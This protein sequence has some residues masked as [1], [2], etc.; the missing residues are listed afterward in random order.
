[1]FT[2]FWFNKQNEFENKMNNAGLNLFIT[3]R[4]LTFQRVVICTQYGSSLG[5]QRFV[6][7]NK[8]FNVQF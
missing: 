3:K 7:A 6:F 8:I 5:Y 1:M 2:V 4:A